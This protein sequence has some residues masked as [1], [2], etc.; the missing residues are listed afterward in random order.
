MHFAPKSGIGAKNRHLCA[1]HTG[2][3]QEFL[4]MTRHFLL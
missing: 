4:E 1:A 2:I 3:A